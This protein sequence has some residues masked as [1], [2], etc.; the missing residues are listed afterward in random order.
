MIPFELESRPVSQISR[1]STTS[2]RGRQVAPPPELLPDDDFEYDE[3]GQRVK[4]KKKKKIEFPWWCIII[5]WILCFITVLACGSMV[6]IYGLSMGEKKTQKWL[7]SMMIAFLSSVLLTQP[8]KVMQWNL[9]WELLSQFPPFRYF[10][11]V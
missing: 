4:K 2:Y 10:T 1:G 11:N 9:G 5:G 3:E 6:V 7:G 8:I